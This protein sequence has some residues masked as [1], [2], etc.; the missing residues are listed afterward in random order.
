MVFCKLVYEVTVHRSYCKFSLICCLFCFWYVLKYP[1]D[2]CCRIIWR[3][4]NSGMFLYHLCVTV[5]CNLVTDCFTTGTLPYNCVVNRSASIFVP[6]YCGL[7]LI[8][9]TQGK[10][11]FFIN[12]RLLHN[13]LYDLVNIFHNLIRVMFYPALFVDNLIMCKVGSGNNLT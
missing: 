6:A 1:C 11:L 13:I 2:L 3:Q 10:N 5:L 8:T 12:A 7:T 4:R 9:D